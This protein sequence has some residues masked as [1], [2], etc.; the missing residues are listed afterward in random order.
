MLRGKMQAGLPGCISG[1]ASL[2]GVHAV[3]QD[4]PVLRDEM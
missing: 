4:R 2:A 1:Q 3:P